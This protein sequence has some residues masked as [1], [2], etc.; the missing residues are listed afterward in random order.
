MENVESWTVERMRAWS[1]NLTQEVLPEVH[2]HERQVAAWAQR[3]LKFSEESA[4]ILIAQGI[5]GDTLLDPPVR[6]LAD[7]VAL[8]PGIPTGKT[9]KMW[10]VI[11]LLAQ[12]STVQ[13]QNLTFDALSKY[14][15]DRRIYNFLNLL[16]HRL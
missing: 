16:A 9:K 8:L 14:R 2:W 3:V 1:L 10:N 7:L 12:P 6:S 4:Q 11:E 5:D 13:L 15:L